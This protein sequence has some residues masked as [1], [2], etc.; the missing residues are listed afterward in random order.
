MTIADARKKLIGFFTRTVW[1]IDTDP[2]GRFNKFIIKSLR[3]LY[4]AVRE[5]TE[6]NL[7]LRAMSLVY[8][9]LLSIVPL[10]AISFSVLKAF[11]VH[12]EIVEPFLLKFLAP[13]GAKG[14][15]ITIKIIGFVENMK[16][17]V[18]GSLGLA[19][20]IYTVISV[21]QKIERAFNSIWKINKTR[22]L[23][24][25]FSDYISVIIIGPV[26]IFS[27]I[28]LTASFMSNTIV[29][30]IVSIEPFGTLFYF[31]AEISPYIIVCA[32][33]TFLYIF[34]PNTKVQFKSALTGGILAG[35][36][37]E[38]AGWAFAS[39]S[40][41]STRYDAIYSGF[42]ILIMF[43]IW[44]YLSWLILLVGA[45]VSFY[46]QYPNFLSARKEIFH[47]SNR[48]RE[49]LAFLIMFKTGYNYYHNKQPLTLHSLVDLLD[50]PVDPIHDV[51]TLLEKNSL[52]L[53]TGDD[54]PAYL[55][56]KDIETITLLELLNAVRVADKGVLA[57]EKQ[58][59]AIPEVDDVIKTLD[60]AI[61]ATL[62]EKTLKD[63]VV[64]L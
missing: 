19:M 22:N 41:S 52:L 26:L 64:S 8:T 45:Q 44:L 14:E 28:G 7:T 60:T 12:N 27:A 29:Q 56:A 46:H 35:V 17:G 2:L 6:G 47:L 24:R 49:R 33:F 5:F 40:V 62:G 61:T 58:V 57:I 37:W 4:V 15:E 25:R 43:M 55:P 9:T 3:L 30:K 16:V 10:L 21:I 23:A 42:A 20:L 31:G 13:L 63:I 53:E 1:E 11:G 32:A 51:L 39:F 18:L 34:I 59:V 38:T 54:P 36:L 48:L 50:L